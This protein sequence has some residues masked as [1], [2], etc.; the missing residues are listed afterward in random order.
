MILRLLD[1]GSS[2]ASKKPSRASRS[3]LENNWSCGWPGS[4]SMLAEGVGERTRAAAA[5]HG[6]GLDDE[7]GGLDEL[8]IGWIGYW[9]IISLYSSPMDNLSPPSST[10]SSPPLYEGDEPLLVDDEEARA[11]LEAPSRSSSNGDQGS[12]EEDDAHLEGLTSS[13]R[14]ILTLLAVDKVIPV[15]LLSEL[16]TAASSLIMYFRSSL[17]SWTWPQQLCHH[18]GRRLPIKLSLWVMPV[19]LELSRLMPASTT[20]L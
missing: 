5:M 9:D 18:C 13:E 19:P 7:L 1:D 3:E 4:G 17:P 6:T 20:K 11:I 15:S 14:E 10:G 8:D 16:E 12:S 2:W